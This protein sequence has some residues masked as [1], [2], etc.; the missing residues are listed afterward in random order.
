MPGPPPTPLHLKLLRGNPGKRPLRAEPEPARAPHCPD[1][2][3]FVTGYAQ[4]EW[5]RVSPELHR[6]KILTV[7][8]TAALAAYCMAYQRW[9]IAEETLAKMTE[10]DD[11][12]RGLLTKTAAGDQRQQPLVRIA[13]DAARDMIKFASEFGMTPV[14]RSRASPPAAAA[15]L[16]AS[17]MGS[18]VRLVTVDGCAPCAVRWMPTRDQTGKSARAA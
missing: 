13:A 5:W 10:G 11:D 12:T 18:S 15:G 1:P 8:D 6:L 9:R 14:A 2:P 3:P 4:D 7:L 17:S 16:R